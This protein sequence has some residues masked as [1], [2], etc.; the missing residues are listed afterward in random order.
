MPEVLYFEDIEIGRKDICGTVTVDA[1][2][3]LAFARIWDPLPIHV[4]AVVAE[5]V[6][7][8]LSAPGVYVLALKQRLLHA[9]PIRAAVTASL[10]YEEVRFHLP[11]RGGDHLTLTIDWLE[12]RLS[13]SRP[14]HGIV[15]H[16]LSLVGPD[17]A[18]AMSHLDTVLVKCR[19]SA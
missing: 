15:S 4:D 19:V 18:V 2:E 11:V 8:G 1:A 17:S 16:R 5:K 6:N 9:A 10:G 14:D 7:G 12:K 3:M 13:A